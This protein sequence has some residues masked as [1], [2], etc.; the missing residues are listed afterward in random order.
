VSR[1]HTIEGKVTPTRND[2]VS[3]SEI[4]SWAWCPESW[5]LE[6]LGE[7]PEN[8]EERARG[9]AFHTR[10]ATLEVSS[11]RLV[12]L[13]WWVLVLGLVVAAVSF[14]LFRVVG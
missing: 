4:A 6:A 1:S 10:T 14:V 3:A 7:E 11:R 2:V 12:A 9:K 8:K 5:R 13:G